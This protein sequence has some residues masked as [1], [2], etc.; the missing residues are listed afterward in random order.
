MM[1]NIKLITIVWKLN[2]IWL[3][4]SKYTHQFKFGCQGLVANIVYMD[5]PMPTPITII[6]YIYI[7]LSTKFKT[8]IVIMEI[9]TSFVIVI[10]INK[11]FSLPLTHTLRPATSVA[12]IMLHMKYSCF[13]IPVLTRIRHWTME[14]EIHYTILCVTYV[15]KAFYCIL[16]R[17]SKHSHQ[18]CEVVLS[19]WK[20][21]PQFNRYVYLEDGEQKMWSLDCSVKWSVKYGW[22]L[23]LKHLQ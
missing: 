3:P 19:K 4:T 13:S 17:Q 8:S 23:R 7:Y 14:C 20:H 21:T 22:Y 12:T 1:S 15:F 2:A 10:K 5:M 6:L 18:W 16:K 9:S 11:S